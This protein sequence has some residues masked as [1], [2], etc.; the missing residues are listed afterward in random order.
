M[1]TVTCVLRWDSFCSYSVVLQMT[2]LPPPPSTQFWVISLKNTLHL[3]FSIT[4][5][6]LSA[7]MSDTH[8]ISSINF[9]NFLS[10]DSTCLCMSFFFLFIFLTCNRLL[11]ITIKKE[12]MYLD[13]YVSKKLKFETGFL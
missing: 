13:Q 10:I 3:I 8:L 2:S 6:Y 4:L 1:A 12:E 5:F 11:V 7:V 9:F